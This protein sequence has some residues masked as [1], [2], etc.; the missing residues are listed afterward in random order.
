VGYDEAIAQ[1]FDEEAL[2]A[3]LLIKLPS[4]L[5]TNGDACSIIPK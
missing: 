4:S 2:I 3:L 1:D 5:E